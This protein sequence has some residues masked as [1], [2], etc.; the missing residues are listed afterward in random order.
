[1]PLTEFQRYLCRLLADERKR[2]GESY[3]AGGLALNEVLHGRRRSEDIDL[4]HDS[5]SALAASWAN[6]RVALAKAGLTVRVV[7]E[8]PS[9]VEAHVSGANEGA[10][11]QWVQDSAYRFFPLVEHP[12]LGL[13]MHPVDLATNKLLAVAGRREPRDWIDILSCDASVQPLGYLA[14]AASGKDP[15][16]GPKAILEEAARARY[17]QLEL[18]RLDFEGPVPDAAALSAH[19]HRAIDE[20]REL[21]A[22]LPLEHVGKV[23]LDGQDLARANPASLPGRLERL[24][25]HEGRIRGAFPEVSGLPAR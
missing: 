11:I 2:S 14:W 19:W 13:T 16:L 4:F 5:E 18:D 17:S 10:L 20:A 7:R 1:M 22:L 6:D 3:V 8:R 9:F 23:V 12:E 24:V 25:F 15:G 21:V